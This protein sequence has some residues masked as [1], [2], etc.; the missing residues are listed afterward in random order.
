[1]GN[2]RNFSDSLIDAYNRK[3]FDSL[4]RMIAPDIDFAHFN[5]D[6]A[7]T[8]R[9]DLLDILRH[10][11]N[12]LMPDRHFE[13]PERV[14]VQDD[15]VIRVAWYNGNLIADVPGF[16]KSGDVVRLKFC[17]IM[18]FDSAGVLVEWKD[19]G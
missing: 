16:G 6:F 5:R 8:S 13:A 17:S 3:D 9:D 14:V 18:R 2:A 7:L 15:T 10:F 12:H 1:M 19:F 4:E 11:A